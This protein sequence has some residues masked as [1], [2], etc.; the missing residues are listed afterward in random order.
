MALSCPVHHGT[1][2]SFAVDSQ[3]G[4]WYCHLQCG[5]GGDMYEL[6]MLLTNSDFKVAV[7][8]IDRIIGM[9]E[10]AVWSKGTNGR[11]PSIERNRCHL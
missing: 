7:A 11:L 10:L 8:E 9:P 1:H 6:Q 3:T 2:D 4:E 5:R